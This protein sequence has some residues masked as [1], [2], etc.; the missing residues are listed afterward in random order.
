MSRQPSI[1]AWIGWA[2]LAALVAG[3]AWWMSAGRGE[4][5]VPQPAPVASEDV[6]E[7]SHEAVRDLC[8]KCHAY[9]PPDCF[10]RHAWRHELRQAYDFMRNS[11]LPGGYP[12]L[13]SV[14]RY[15]E[16]RA[17]AE[18]VIPAPP[19]PAAAPPVTFTATPVP[20]PRSEGPLPASKPYP[21]TTFVN[22]VHLSNR[23]RPD[24]LVCDA[25]SGRVMI[26]DPTRPA[27][28]WKALATLAAPARAEVVDLDG[29]GLLDLV[30]ADLGHFWPTNAKFGQVVWLRGRLDGSFTPIVLAERLGRV[31]DVQVAD[32][33][34]VGRLDLVVAVYGG[35][36]TGEILLLENHTTDWAMPR[37]VPRVLDE[38]HGGIHVPA[39][40]L[41]GD[42]KPD[43]V[44]LIA[45]EHETIE[46][47]V[48][49]GK[50]AFR[51]ETIYTAPHPAFGCSGI[52]LIDM[53]RD[54]KLDVLLTNGDSLDPPLLLKPY[55]G[56]R[57]L[58]NRGVFPF[59]EHHLGAMPGVMRAV[60]ADVDGDRDLDVVA[61]SFL[62]PAALPR[63]A[64]A[65]L[66]SI[67]LFEQSAPG[68]FVR[69]SLERGRHEHMTCVAGD[70][71][72]DGKT[73]LVTGTLC[74][75]DEPGNRPAVTLWEPGTK[76]SVR[77]SEAPHS[78]PK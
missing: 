43:F 67:A 61:V 47:F 15:Y 49:Q 4:R 51:K 56:I 12:S 52:Q 78:L 53:N 19:A 38:R 62:S 32:F 7:A 48:N 1:S 66:D 6:A 5:A 29:D 54:G 58:E 68:T 65:K 34:G 30:V 73:R 70:W 44:A 50:G 22:L 35:R 55:H 64:A 21:G 10:P 63:G 24:L 77:P 25:W 13:E 74:R 16:A 36:T 42:G 60:A 33:R 11:P 76:E 26:C 45:Q 57:W 9:P 20:H 14:A 27:D 28:S 23:A 2:G 41:N 17:P 3:V 72:G 75:P 37:F 8:G 18:F 71:R 69:H 46:A 39:C 31:A 59:T 40:D